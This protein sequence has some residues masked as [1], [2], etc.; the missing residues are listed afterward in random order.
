[1]LLKFSAIFLFYF[2]LLFA[3][4]FPV[5]AET[6]AETNQKLAWIHDPLFWKELK[7]EDKV[8]LIKSLVESLKEENIIIRKNPAFYAEQIDLNEKQNPKLFFKPVGIQL[9]TLAIMYGDYDN[10]Q[11]PFDLIKE[12]FGEPFYIEYIHKNMM[13]TL[14]EE[15]D[16]WRE[17]NRPKEQEKS[18]KKK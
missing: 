14:Q 6:P 18:A 11:N 16:K 4:S 9:N 17:K 8:R 10:G 7:H 3:I 13:V 12:I 5:Q 2:L 1:M 15:Y